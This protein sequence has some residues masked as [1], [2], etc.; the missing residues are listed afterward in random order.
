MFPV[1]LD[2]VTVAYHKKPVLQ[3]ISLQVPEGKLI[4]IIGPNGA[5]KSTLIKTILGLVPRASGDIS[6]YG[7]DYKDQRTRIGYVPQRG[8]VD[9]DFPTSPLD[10]VLMGRYGRIGLLKRPKK[11]DVEMAKAALAKVGML[12]YAK[13]QISQLSGGQ[14]QRVFLAR[15]LCQNAD[16]YFMDEPFAGVDAATERAIMTLL[17]ELKE[18]GKTVLVVH[19]DLQTA[20]DYFDWILLLHLRKI[21]FGPAENVFTIE[22]LQKTYGGRLTFLK[23]KVLAEGH[24]E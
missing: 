2:N 6:I 20:E 24:K 12:D 14:Q 8:S 11:A 9:W 16:I 15:A 23:D 10:V 5:G 13:R 7:K 21:A 17:A 3:D 18:K 22:N 4:G 1:E 19:H